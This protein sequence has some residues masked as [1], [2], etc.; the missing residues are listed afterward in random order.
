MLS[1]QTLEF[2]DYLTAESHDAYPEGGVVWTYVEGA[3]Q[4][5]SKFVNPRR[6]AEAVDLDFNQLS[7]WFEAALGGRSPATERSSNMADELISFLQADLGI[8]SFLWGFQDNSYDMM[9]NIYM[10]RASDNRYFA[11][12]LWW[13]VD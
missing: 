4:A 6:K 11:L 5:H 10:M 9:A 2:L 8:N 12:E 7:L 3:N 1:K 13:S